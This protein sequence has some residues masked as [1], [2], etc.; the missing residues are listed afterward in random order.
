MN[1]NQNRLRQEA[2]TA[3]RAEWPVAR[4]SELAATDTPIPVSGDALARLVAER[5]ARA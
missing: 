5:K 2:F 3:I 4:L 1:I